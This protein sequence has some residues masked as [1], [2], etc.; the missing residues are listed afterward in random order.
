MSSL[1]PQHTAAVN[2]YFQ[3]YPYNM[4]ISTRCTDCAD[5][6]NHRNFIG[7]LEDDHPYIAAIRCRC[8]A[9]NMFFCTICQSRLRNQRTV[10]RHITS[11]HMTRGCPTQVTLTIS[12]PPTHASTC[13]THR[14]TKSPFDYFLSKKNQLFFWQD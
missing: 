11:H 7:I 6:L 2:H 5:Q 9:D 14:L 4:S 10:R 3:S 8:R 1:Y 13:A 12:H